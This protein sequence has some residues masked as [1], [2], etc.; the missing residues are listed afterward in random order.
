MRGP[1]LGLLP[2]QVRRPAQAA[3]R[4]TT[5]QCAVRYAAFGW[6]VTTGSTTPTRDPEQAQALWSMLAGAAV[7]A[8][9]GEAFDVVETDTAA[10]R[11]ALLRLERLGVPVGPVLWTTATDR[12]GFLVQPETLGPVSSLFEGGY[13]LCVLSAASSPSCPGPRADGCAGC[14][15]RPPSAP[16]PRC[17]PRMSCSAGSPEPAS[18]NGTELAGAG[19]GAPPRTRRTRRRPRASPAASAAFSPRRDPDPG[20]RR[21]LSRRFRFRSAR[22]RT[23]PGRTAPGRPRP[24]RAR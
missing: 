1:S 19:P 14:A 5:R 23:R 21:G 7:H 20:S 17:R 22:R 13:G 18:R 16:R 3:A 9:C 12:V 4:V 10:G 24:R 15:S 2:R 11:A 6:P 8:A